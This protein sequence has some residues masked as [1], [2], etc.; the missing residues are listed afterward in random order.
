VERTAD[1]GD[2]RLAVPPYRED[3]ALRLVRAPG[4]GR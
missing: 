2:L 3:V 1:A 4:G